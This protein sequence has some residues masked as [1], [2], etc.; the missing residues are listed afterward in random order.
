VPSGPEGGPAQIELRRRLRAVRRGAGLNQADMADLAG[1][2]HQTKAS[3]FELGQQRPTE[4]EVRAWAGAA[5]ADA[6]PLLAALAA[7]G[8]EYESWQEI[9]D[10]DGSPAGYQEG[11]RDLEARSVEVWKFQPGVIPG[12]LQTAAYARAMIV[13]SHDLTGMPRADQ[14]EDLVA[15]R[16]ARQSILF[17]PLDGREVV[18][19]MLEG[20]LRHPQ[21]PPEAMRGQLARLAV[22]AED[23]PGA[24]LGVVPFDVP[25]PVAPQSGVSIYDRR[26]AAVETATG[27]QRVTDLVQVG[28]WVA[29]FEALRAVAVTGAAMAGLVRRDLDLIS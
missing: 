3:K 21:C 27:E 18:I 22:L 29:G 14:V 8:Q 12:L 7:A 13:T 9:H 20:V 6:G 19:L 23:A 28:R 10:R 16:M 26:L 17:E 2:G 15:A 1:L 4:A 5:G 25:L 24:V 11:I